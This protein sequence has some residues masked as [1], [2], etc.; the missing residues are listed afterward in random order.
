[1]AG[2]K[3]VGTALRGRWDVG[4][5]G[6]ICPPDPGLAGCV[7][8]ILGWRGHQGA[9]A[10]GS[11][12]AAAQPGACHGWAELPRP[13]LRRSS[14]PRAGRQ[15]LGRVL[16]RVLRQVSVSRRLCRVK[17]TGPVADPGPRQGCGEGCGIGRA[18]RLP[19]AQGFEAASP[20][21][22]KRMRSGGF[23]G[24]SVPWSLLHRGT[25][26]SA[27]IFALLRLS[28]APSVTTALGCLQT[29]QLPPAALARVGAHTRTSHTCA[30]AHA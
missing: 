1:M 22:L 11:L 21:G 16:R 25:L 26:L 17:P 28:L 8:T 5:D 30:E 12:G 24:I 19:R 9:L 7:S 6:G 23:W 4:W 10:P 2:E 13:R 18:L 20:E 3:R 14:C 29:E 15:V 27:C